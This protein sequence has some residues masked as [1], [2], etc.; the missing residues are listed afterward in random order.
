ME[1]S[2][3]LKRPTIRTRRV[4]MAVPTSASW[5]QR[6]VRGATAYARQRGPNWELLFQAGDTTDPRKM[7]GF[8]QPD[9]IILHPPTP[10]VIDLARAR[11]K[12]VVLVGESGHLADW[13]CVSEDNIAVGELA[14]EHLGAKGFRNLA[15][16]GFP[17]EPYSDLRE[18]G[19][20]GK[21]RENG[22]TLV[23]QPGSKW[24]AAP[25]RA[26]AELE[27]WLRRLPRPTGLLLAD[28]NLGA[29]AAWAARQK[30]IRVPE[31][32]ALLTVNNDELLCE[33]CSPAL[34]SID[35][36]GRQIGY[37]AAQRVD[38]LLDGNDTQPR[39]KRVEP[40]GVIERRSTESLAIE[41]PQAA[42]AVRFIRRRALE[43]I[44]PRD[45]LQ[46]I[47]VS[48]TGLEL[49]FKEILGRTIFQ[50]IQRVK[51]EHARRLLTETDM[52]VET[53]ARRCG[54]R[55]GSYFATV[56]RR[57]Q[58]V[59]PSQLRRRHGSGAD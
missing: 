39:V 56:F 11:N 58:G 16:W 37:K 1:I 50:E 38:A 19:F 20:F 13:P 32:L 24:D 2:Q 30:D 10:D 26:P 49:R 12:P 4:L 52:K 18:E 7:L 27:E 59:S 47:P 43:G 51:L 53:I 29:Q 28:C 33:L 40:L 6:I 44:T 36:G 57:E 35:Q 21:A 3:S 48:R 17:G 8:G 14:A 42:E 15:F 9:A 5:G 46:E 54:F 31:M 22:L 25:G 55:D 45:V 34:S 23:A 41:D